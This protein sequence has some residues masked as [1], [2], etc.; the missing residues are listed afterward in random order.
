MATLTFELITPEG[1][2]FRHDVYEVLLPTVQGQIGVLAN[3]SPLIA[4]AVPGVISIRHTSE[5]SDQQLEHFATSG[6][7]I[8]INDNCLRFLANTAEHADAIDEL[9]AQ[10]ALEK[11]QELHKTAED[12]VLLADATSLIER[13]LVRLKVADLKKRRSHHPKIDAH[14]QKPW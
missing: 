6:G 12:H 9:R 10:E 11:A 14:G 2:K 3:H 7:L 5:D 4:L 1:I 13:N 8:E